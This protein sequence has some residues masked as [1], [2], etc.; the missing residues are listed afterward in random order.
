MFVHSNLSVDAG[1]LEFRLNTDMI[2]IPTF[3]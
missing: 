3:F 2:V 1:L